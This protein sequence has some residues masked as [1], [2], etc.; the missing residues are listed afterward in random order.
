MQTAVLFDL[1]C[2]LVNRI[3]QIRR[4]AVR[5]A[6][7]FR[8]NLV[9]AD[10]E[11]L[12]D[13]ILD[14][15]GLGY[16]PATRFTDVL[17]QLE[18]DCLPTL[19]DLESHWYANFPSLAVPMDGAVEVLATLQK[20]GVYL[21]IITNGSVQS[22]RTKIDQLGLD[23]YCQAIVISGALGIKKPDSAIFQHAL[24]TLG[25]SAS[26]AWFVGDHPVND[27][28]GAQRAGLTPVWLAGSHPWPPDRE[29]PPYQITHVSELLRLL[30]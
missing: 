16:R 29:P 4:Y 25:V 28:I 12:A 18:W 11:H 9:H 23:A 1:D 22:Q 19:V 13:V 21:G 7:H 30:D 8:D 10:P 2:T 6:T 20:K 15:D 26:S 27:I 24:D 14:A 3:E 5:F 17:E